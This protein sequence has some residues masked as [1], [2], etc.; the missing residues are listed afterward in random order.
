LSIEYAPLGFVGL[1][2]PQANTVVESECGILLPPGVGQLAGRLTSPRATV[3]ERLVDYFESLET[4]TR[5]F[6]G[7]PLRALGFACTGSSYLAGREREDEMLHRLSEQVGCQVTSSARSVIDA[8][9]A[10]DARHIALVSPYPDA[11]TRH[12]I[13]Y[14]QSR[15]LMVDAVVTI[16]SEA[17]VGQHPVYGLGSDDVMRAIDGLSGHFDAVVLLGTGLPTLR[18]ILARPR[19]GTAPLISCTLALA[20]R[21]FHALQDMAPSAASL[22][23]WVGGDGWSDRYRQRALPRHDG[24]NASASFPSSQEHGRRRPDACRAPSAATVRRP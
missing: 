16:A 7:V 1:L 17:S 23:E 6:A 24:V 3:E 19:I 13:G 4:T 2:T 10:I 9:R 8:L 14:W 21:C 15:D 22:L 18:A 5:Q 20:W 11:L 12:S